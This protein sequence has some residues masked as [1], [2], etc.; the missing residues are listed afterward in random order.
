[1]VLGVFFCCFFGF[2]WVV[3]LVGFPFLGF[4][5]LGAAY[6]LG[7]LYPLYLLRPFEF[8]EYNITYPK[9]MIVF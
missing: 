4:V 5:F 6:E 2:G 7:A 9:K 1:V 8:L 3:S